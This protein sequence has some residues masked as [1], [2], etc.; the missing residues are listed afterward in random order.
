MITSHPP[1]THRRHGRRS[2][3]TLVE[4]LLVLV[5]LAVLAAIVYPRISGRTEQAKVTS[6][7]TQITLLSG[8]INNFE[9][10]CGYYPKSLDDLFTAP[11]NA[12]GWHG[13][14][15][16][17]GVPLDPWGAPYTYTFPGKKNPAGFDLISAGPPGKETPITN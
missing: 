13:P 9:V 10:D 8:A 15:L 14:Y 7:S 17:K 16:E 12:T 2:G 5:I 3:F 1:F 11:S 4:M 6:A